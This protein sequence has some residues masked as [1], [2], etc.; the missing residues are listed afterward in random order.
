MSDLLSQA[1]GDGVSVREFFMSWGAKVHA[2]YKGDFDRISEVPMS[3]ALRFTDLDELY[4]VTLGPDGDYE[5]EDDEADD[6]PIATVEGLGADWAL[7]KARAKRLSASL[8]ARRAELER[9][10]TKRMTK[11]ILAELERF[12]GVI[13]AKVGAVT[14]R[15][16]LNHYEASEDAPSF[17]IEISEQLFDQVAS[18]EVEP[19]ELM[20]R[21][22]ISGDKKF[23]LNL[24][25]FFTK[26]FN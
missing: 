3:F 15:V 9:T 2:H 26:H 19:S 20:K 21:A 24:A 25:G 12:D 1:L 4:T 22:K 14:W 13:E 23:A 5:V 17:R 16:I 8:E 7:V 18:G 10:I 11:K 6:F